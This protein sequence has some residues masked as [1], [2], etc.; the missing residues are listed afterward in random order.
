MRREVEDGSVPDGGYARVDVE[1]EVGPVKGGVRIGARS[2]LRRADEILRPMLLPRMEGASKG[3]RPNTTKKACLGRAYIGDVG[4]ERDYEKGKTPD[5]HELRRPIPRP[6][7]IFLYSGL[8]F[9]Q[10]RQEDS[11]T[12]H[13]TRIRR[14]CAG[15]PGV[16]LLLRATLTSHTAS[17]HPPTSPPSSLDVRPLF[18]KRAV[19][20]RSAGGVFS[21]LSS[22]YP[23]PPHSRLPQ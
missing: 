1:V 11:L 4:V 13:S 15:C 2:S 6:A 7:F 17:L 19:F 10:L 3:A 12:N 5:K 20:G 8:D 18:R 14:R 22:S 21:S 9:S 16:A 23:T